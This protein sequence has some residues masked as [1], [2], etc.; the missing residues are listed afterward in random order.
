MSRFRKE[1]TAPEETGAVREK[2]GNGW[3]KNHWCALSLC[4]IVIVA[5]A[6]RTV[7]AYGISADGGFALSGGSSAQYHLHVIESILNGSYSMTDS[8]VNYPVGGLNVYPPLFDFIGAGIASV[9]TAFGMG[10]TEAASAAIG[11]LNP[12]IGALTCIPVFLVAKEMFD[13]RVGVVAALV[14]AFLALPISTTVFSSGTEY[15]LAAFLVAFMAWFAVKMVKAADAEDADRKAVL[16]NALITGVFLALAALTWNGFRFLVVIMVV[17]MVLQIVVDRFR[18][19]DFQTVL[20]GYIVAILVGTLIP[21]AYYLPAGLWDAVY[22]GPLLM[23]VISVVLSL[24][25]MAIR[26]KPWIV[27]VP[28]LVV[29]FV[30]IAAVLAVAAPELYNALIFGNSIYTGSIME[31]LASSYVSMSNV[32]AY[33]GWLTMWLP[34]CYAIYSTYVYLRRDHSATRLFVTLW[35]FGMFFAVWTSYAN[36]AVVG[37]VFAVGSAVVIVRVLEQANLKDWYTSMKTAGFPGLFRK[38][39]KPFPFASVII[40]A[41]LIVV[42]NVSFAVDAGISN[43]SDADYYFSGNTQYTIKTGDSYPIG[44]VWDEYGSVEKDGAL[45]SWIDYANDAVAQGGFDTVVDSV[46]GGTSAVAQ[47]YMS[48]GAAGSVAAM[49][50]RLIMSND[51]DDFASCFGDHSDVFADIRSYIEDPS[52]AVDVINANPEAFGSIRSDITDENAV[53]LAAIERITGSM[54]TVEIMNAYDAVCDVSG[55]KISYVIA[56]SSMLPL[57]Y[58]DGDTF[59]T[60]A[61]FGDYKVD[62]Y[63][64][65]TQFYSYNTYY[66]YTVYTDAMYDTF[67]WRA[68]IGPSAAEAGFTGSN[69]SYNYLVALSSSDGSEGSVKA[70]PGYGLA[71]YEVVYWQV[72]YNPDS[73]ALVTDDGW[74]YMDAYEAIA[75]QA[76]EGGSINYLSSIVMLH[77]TGV[78]AEPTTFDGT[79]TYS[80]HAVDGATVSVYQYSETFGQYTLYSESRTIGGEFSVL[81]P[82][83]DY[84]IQISIGDVVLQSFTADS[85]VQNYDI[86]ATTVDGAVMVGDDVY[87]AEDM[88]LK[89][90]GGATLADDAEGIV[91]SDSSEIPVVDGIVDISSV[92]PGTYSYTLYNEAGDAIGTGSVTIYPGSNVGFEVSPTTRT[93]TVTVNDNFGDP[94]TDGAIVVATNQTNMAQFT[95]EVEDGKA[96]ITVVSGQYNLSMGQGYVSMYSNNVNASSGNRTATITAYA[97]QSVTVSGVSAGTVLMVSAGTFSTVSYELGGSVMFDVPVGLA[98]ENMHYTVYGVSGNNVYHAVY[99]GGSSVSVASGNAITVSGQLMDGDNGEEGTVSF[100]SGNDEYFT[101]ATDSEGKFNA[102]LPSGTYTVAADNGSDMVYFG[103]VGATS[104]TDMGEIDLVDGRRIGYTLRYES[105]QSGSNPYL[106]FV[107]GVIEFTYNEKAYTLY[108]MTNTSGVVNFY[109][110][111]DVDSVISLNNAD[112]T[113]DNSVF[114]CEELTREV[115]AGTSNNTSSITIRVYDAEDEDEKNYV[116]VQSVTAPYDMEIQYY[117]DDDDVT[118]DLVAGQTYSLRP[119]SYDVTIDGSTGHYFKG[120]LYLYPGTTEFYGLEDVENVVTVEVQNAETDVVSVS[121]TDGTYHRFDGGYYLEVGYEYYLTSTNTDSDGKALIAYGYVDLTGTT[122]ASYSIDMTASEKRMQVNGNVGVVADGTITVSYQYRNAAV[123]H[124]FDVTDGAYTLVLPAGVS[125]VDVSVEVSATI[126]SEERHFAATGEFTGLAIVE[127]DG[128][129]TPQVRNIAVLTTDAPADEDEEQP[130]F[131]AAIRSSTFAAGNAEV[132]VEI[133][134]NSGSARTYLVTGGSE[135]ALDQAYSVNIP[136]GG[137]QTVTV[138]GYYDASRVAP[139]TDGVSVTVEDINGADTQTLDITDGGDSS[140]AVDVEILKAGDEGATSNGVSAYQYLYAITIVNNNTCTHDV[141]VNVTGVPSG[142]SVAIMDEDGKIV[143]ENG[144]AFK[145]YGLQTT[146]LYVKLMLLEPGQESTA[147]P[148]I[149]ASVQAGGVSEQLTLSAGDVEVTTDDMSVSGDNAFDERSGVPGGIWFLVAV[150]L[151]ML[152]AIFWLASKRGVFSRR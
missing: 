150:I 83:G 16:V 92:L 40:V 7:F 70:M 123:Q 58:G 11:V 62:G 17:A 107:M 144:T 138:R 137:T 52:K 110:P 117:E 49:M 19:R 86:P 51:V 66:G 30:V 124:D 112:G 101:V 69:A 14:F 152:V 85:A 50:M 44:G 142:W 73:D 104:S 37:S 119:G 43:N 53:Y 143:A 68:M 31:E 114:H 4:I 32:S 23:A 18:G 151:L 38:M 29:V 127:N 133:T 75:K 122:Q 149:T 128:A 121:T 94:V 21:A 8:A 77:Y 64:A 80:G 3:L 103:T 147:V 9:L 61:Y 45:V 118:Q 139:G 72:M 130:G 129:V 87:D 116:K 78:S 48:S 67:L 105:G 20:F 33:Y 22:S 109:I 46:G 47:M 79:V 93:I 120:T 140:G 56:D 59:S 146:V 74:E 41:F 125:S 132:T 6:L 145:A 84:R 90:T 111:D 63:G 42:P 26:S 55:E 98:T 60:I 12:I 102:L 13:K 108:G 100:I 39:I 97:A 106:P 95:A 57:Q 148:D 35:M 134:N 25:F 141:T 36:A 99:T 126:D 91:D 24:V 115:S 2:S 89:L 96:V 113:L 131:T 1:S 5:F 54:S 65:A 15:G 34:I 81:V 82:S 28:A 76:A 27:V 10:T 71:G 88:I 136:A 135:L